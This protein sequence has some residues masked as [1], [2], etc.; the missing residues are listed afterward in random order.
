MFIDLADK[1][2]VADQY[3]EHDFQSVA[4][5]AYELE[6]KSGRIWSLRVEHAWEFEGF[7]ESGHQSV[8]SG[9]QAQFELWADTV[10][11]I[12]EGHYSA[13]DANT[14]AHGSVSVNAASQGLDLEKRQDEMGSFEASSNTQAS[15]PIRTP[16]TAQMQDHSLSHNA[17]PQQNLADT[18]GTQSPP[19]GTIFQSSTRP[20]SNTT[21]NSGNPMGQEH[22]NPQHAQQ[23]LPGQS[24]AFDLGSTV[25]GQGM[26]PG[27]GPYQQGQNALQLGARY[28]QQGLNQPQGASFN[29]QQSMP[30]VISGKPQQGQVIP[31]GAGSSTQQPPNMSQGP[32]LTIQQRP[33]M[34]QG[35]SGPARNQTPPRQNMQAYP[36]PRP[37]MPGILQAGGPVQGNVRN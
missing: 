30:L 18:Q 5:A 13:N 1:F 25:P 23:M 19:S 27:Q 2:Q 12:E 22:R 20:S 31:P 28:P 9:W 8:I 32:P 16:Q 3:S 14:I 10:L 29:Q 6:A 15:M 24:T 17:L 35:P 4:S 26:P 21:M 11:D 37:Q 7:S 36:S 34:A 33:N